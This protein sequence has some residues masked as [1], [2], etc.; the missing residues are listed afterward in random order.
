MTK[1][2]V[3]AVALLLILFSAN[4]AFS[5][6][7][8]QN[9]G[10]GVTVALRHQMITATD[11]VNVLSVKDTIIVNNPLGSQAKETSISIG[12]PK[13]HS[14]LIILSA[15]GEDELITKEG[16]LIYSKIPSGNSQI[17]VGYLVIIPDNSTRFLLSTT[18]DNP[19]A[20]YSI[21]APAEI[22][23]MDSNKLRAGTIQRVGDNDY[24]MMG[25]SDLESGTV[26]EATV[27]QVSNGG[28]EASY[29]PE[30]HSPGH[31]KFWR[32]SPF[33]GIDAHLFI[34]LVVIIPAGLIGFAFYKRKQGNP[35]PPT[36]EDNE[37]RLFQMLTK[38]N[39]VLQKKIKELE[40]Q[41]FDGQIDDETYSQL[42]QAYRKRLQSVKIRL[43]EFTD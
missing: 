12:L 27:M 20:E 30:F 21:L 37:E 6:D 22:F 25:A 24:Q 41:R 39:N 1:F 18:L 40:Q 2:R 43:K 19:T 34:L 7:I 23:N 8:V 26:I 29:N 31:V 11:Q 38:R 9:N 17:E 16:K 42:S 35:E 28:I 10:V 15:Q 14:Q 3:M 13:N 36:E 4:P 33:S 5:Q 32:Q